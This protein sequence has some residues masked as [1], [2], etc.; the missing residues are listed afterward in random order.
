MQAKMRPNQLLS[1]LTLS[2]DLWRERDSWKRHI[3]MDIGLDVQWIGH[4]AEMKN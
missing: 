4:V 1:M 3:T 2:L